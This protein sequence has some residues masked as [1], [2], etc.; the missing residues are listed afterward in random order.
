MKRSAVLVLFAFLVGASALVGATRITSVEPTMASPGA[1]LVATGTDLTEVE[2]LFLTV[3]T[4]DIEVE[5]TGK[6]AEEIRF[7]LPADLAHGQYK[8][9]IQTGGDAPALMVQPITC[10]VM[11]AAEIT[12]RQSQLEK[13]EQ[14]I[15]AAASAR[16]ETPPAK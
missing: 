1:S 8:L 7:K 10:E 3:D 14:R 15:D 2:L 5:I 6:T 4:T 13:E 12:E 16:E 9:M 11:S